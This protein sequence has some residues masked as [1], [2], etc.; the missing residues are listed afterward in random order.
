MIV[1]IYIHIPFCSYKCDFCD[2][3]A[4]AGLSNLEDDYCQIV[5]NEIDS[6]LSQ[7]DEKPN[8]SSIFYG[9][10]TPGLLESAKIAKIQTKLLN[11]VHLTDGAEITLETTPSAISQSKVSDWLALGINRLSIGLQSLEDSEL[12]AIGRGHSSDQALSGICQAVEGGFTNVCCDLM[13]GLPTQT[14]AS[15]EKSLSKLLK[16]SS[17]LK[18]IQHISAYALSIAQNPPLLN[19]FPKNSSVYPDDDLYNQMYELLVLTLA[20]SAFTQYEISNFSKTNYQSRH[21]LNYWS[22]REYQAFGMSAHRYLDGIRSSNWRSLTR[23]MRD[24]LGNET[25]EVIDRKTKMKE[26]IMLGLRLTAGIDL[27]AFEQEH[28][29]NL[30]NQF[31]RELKKLKSGNFLEVASGRLKLTSKAVLVSNLV[32]SEFFS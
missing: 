7:L 26:A 17:E 6:R 23:Y 29:I 5:C 2:L 25:S 20:E 12:L 24:F 14:L 9:G 22:N 16:L 10:G 28:G 11:W 1:S 30:L 18:Y 31:D 27:V 3:A 32:I 4:V 8:I 15:W 13:Y 21:N 19:R